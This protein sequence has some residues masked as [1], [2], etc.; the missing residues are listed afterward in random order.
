MGRCEYCKKRESLI[1]NTIRT[2][3]L[4]QEV[5]SIFTLVFGSGLGKHLVT[6]YIAPIDMKLFEESKINVAYKEVVEL[7]TL[8]SRL[9]VK[10]RNTR[11]IYFNIIKMSLSGMDQSEEDKLL[12]RFYRSH[13]N[14][15]DYENEVR[16]N[17]IIIG[18]FDS[19][20]ISEFRLEEFMKEM[21]STNYVHYE[22]LIINNRK[23]M[24][25]ADVHPP[26]IT[27]ARMLRKGIGNSGW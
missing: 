10:I 5:V 24:Y 1:L 18:R 21:A 16:M 26:L 15:F 4:D 19:T 20:F 11:N 27:F 25:A 14:K 8:N 3:Y 2:D 23:S 13:I 12:N 22:N 7:I 17:N 6:K 9:S